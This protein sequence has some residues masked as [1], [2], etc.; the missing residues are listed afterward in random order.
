MER[1]IGTLIVMMDNISF[2]VAYGLKG[3][4]MEINVKNTISYSLNQGRIYRRFSIQS[5]EEALDPGHRI[6]N[7]LW[8]LPSVLVLPL[9][10][11]RE[12]LVYR[13]TKNGLPQKVAT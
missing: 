1:S 4:N 3:P 11:S 2:S 8:S 7:I 10:I 6:H 5:R 12:V 9:R 13:C